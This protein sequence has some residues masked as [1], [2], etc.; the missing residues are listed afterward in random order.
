[1]ADF[2][3]NMNEPLTLPRGL[4][5]QDPACILPQSS[6]LYDITMS[7]IATLILRQSR[8]LRLFD[9][10]YWIESQTRSI[11]SLPILHF[12][13]NSIVSPD[14]G[15]AEGFSGPAMKEDSALISR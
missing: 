6:D 5:P 2:S 8:L 15:N 14:D 10:Q 13:G 12:M 4:M 1:M 9:R 7:K 3:T 11:E